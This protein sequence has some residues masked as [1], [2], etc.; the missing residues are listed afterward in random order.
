VSRFCT[1]LC[2][3]LFK[4]SNATSSPT[5]SHEQQATLDLW[6]PVLKNAFQGSQNH[7]L[8]NI[9]TLQIREKQLAGYYIVAFVIMLDSGVRVCAQIFVLPAEI[10]R[11]QQGACFGWEDLKELRIKR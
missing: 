9:N 5:V 4:N 11:L 3:C 2:I 1:K 6:M 8:H 10:G 7:R